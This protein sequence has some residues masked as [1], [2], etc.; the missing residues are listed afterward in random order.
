MMVM[1]RANLVASPTVM[2]LTPAALAAVVGQL[3]T[4]FRVLLPATAGAVPVPTALTALLLRSM[5]RLVT[6]PAPV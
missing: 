5:R 2:V 3:A 6:V 4:K 1:P